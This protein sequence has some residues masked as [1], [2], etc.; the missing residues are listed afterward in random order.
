[1]R[2]HRLKQDREQA[3]P[4][5]S[6]R[7]NSEHL[8]KDRRLPSSFVDVFDLLRQLICLTCLAKLTLQGFQSH[9]SHEVGVR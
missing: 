4:S 5:G 3:G 9:F 1:M 8:A 6:F 2:L 7:Q